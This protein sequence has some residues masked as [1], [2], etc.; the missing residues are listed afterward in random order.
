MARG[1]AG[2]IKLDP[3]R[4]AIRTRQRHMQ[5]PRRRGQRPALQQQRDDDDDKGDVEIEIRFRQS[6]QHRDR[7]QKDRDRAAQAG[8]RNKNLLPPAEAKRRQT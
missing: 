2:Q 6:D 7:R 5:P 3:P 1:R 4:P 8:P